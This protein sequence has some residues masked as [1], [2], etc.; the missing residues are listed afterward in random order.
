MNNVKGQRLLSYVRDAVSCSR[1]I[2]R[3]LITLFEALR[4]REL[5][6]NRWRIGYT[7]PVSG[8]YIY[9]VLSAL[10]SRQERTDQKTRR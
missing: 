3:N 6:A 9:P 4:K 2:S 8:R 1:S 10:L 7:L 5:Q